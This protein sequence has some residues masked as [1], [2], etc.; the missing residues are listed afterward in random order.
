M[1]KKKKKKK[2]NF[3][4]QH[5]PRI[6]RE[7]KSRETAQQARKQRMKPDNSTEKDT[8]TNAHNTIQNPQE[9]RHTKKK[10]T[11]S[12]KKHEE[13]K[14]KTSKASTIEEPSG[15]RKARKQRKKPGNSA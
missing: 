5:D 9:R 1:K 14:K 15:N 6:I 11:I 3:K 10:N 7:P 12:K 8:S 2:K 4:S 13:K